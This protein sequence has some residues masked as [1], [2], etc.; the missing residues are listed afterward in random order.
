MG[1]IIGQGKSG[2]GGGGASAAEFQKMATLDGNAYNLFEEVKKIRKDSRASGYAV[3]VMGLYYK[4]YNSL[5][6]KGADAYITCD[7]DFYEATSTTEEITHYWHDDCSGKLDRYVAF[8]LGSENKEI[9]FDLFSRMPRALVVDG[10]CGTIYWVAQTWNFSYVSTTENS[11]I[12]SI[13]CMSDTLI[14]NAK[15]N[16]N[17]YFY[18]GKLLDSASRQG[19][20]ISLSGARYAVID[21]E[22]MNGSTLVQDDYSNPTTQTLFLPNLKTAK[23]KILY[24][25]DSN[26]GKTLL[27][28]IAPKL[29]SCDG[30]FLNREY[31]CNLS[32]IRRIVIPSCIEIKSGEFIHVTNSPLTNSPNL[33]HIEIGNGFISNLNMKMFTFANCL[34]T[35]ANNLVEDV[36]AHPTWSNLDQWLFNFEHLIVDKLADLSGQTAKTITLAAA[37]YAAITSEIRA[38]MSAKNWNLASA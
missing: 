10:H 18:V 11:S 31:K 32:A 19:R 1:L 26:S 30:L 21:I 23:N 17:A 34:L 3:V 33:I 14:V 29:V 2:G 25:S 4:G 13:E 6:L 7:G 5:V 16:Q 28:F 9:K 24:S 37:P 27:E 8:L 35:D 22:E 38:K 12:R 20:G 15:G 36:V